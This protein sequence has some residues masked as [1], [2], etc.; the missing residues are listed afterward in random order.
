MLNNDLKKNKK[1]YIKKIIWLIFK[2]IIKKV[3]N[4]IKKY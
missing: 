4:I 2:Y 3:V 1:F